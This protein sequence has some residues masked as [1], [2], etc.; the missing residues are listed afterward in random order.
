MNKTVKFIFMAAALI[1]LTLTATHPARAFESRNGQHIVIEEGEVIEDDLYASAETVTVNGVIKGDLV[2]FGASITV[3]GTVEG[4]V[5]AAGQAVVI[6]GNITDDARIAG[7]GL[8]I[9]PDAIIGDDLVAAGASLETRDGSRVGGDLAMGGAQAL[10][11]GDVTGDVTA[12][13]AALELR[14]QFDGNVSAYVDVTTDS[15]EM[16]PLN[17]YMTDMPIS[18]PSVPAGLT[19][20]DSARITGNLEYTSAFDLN[21]PASAVGGKITRTEPELDSDDIR[22]E[23]TPAEKTVA[24]AL[25]LIRFAATLILFGLCL[26]WLFPNFMKILPETLRTKPAASLGWGAIAWAAFFFALLAILLATIFGAVV[27]GMFTL[28]AVSGVIVLVGVLAL[29][30]LMAGFLLA[31]SYLAKIVVGEWIGT[32]LLGKINPSLAEH[33]FWPMILGVIVVAAAIAILRFPFLPFGFIGALLNFIVILFGLGALW[34]WG[35]EKFGRPAAG[36]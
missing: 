10:L 34:L 15:E 5:M 17:L 24:W 6:N 23:Q 33:K 31:A 22:L 18:I 36:Q 12:G 30:I 26:G 11:A 21:I 35:R 13:T 20:S 4:D 1:G 14:G 2:A 19:V 7:A 9:G 16:P 32:W 27:F 3:N 25:D 28:G 8:Q 29:L